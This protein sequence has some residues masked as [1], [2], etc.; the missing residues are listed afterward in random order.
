M[1]DLF[2]P[3]QQWPVLQ[4]P[5]CPTC[6]TGADVV[7]IGDADRID[8]GQANIWHCRSCPDDFATTITFWPVLEGPDCPYCGQGFTCWA[9]IDPDHGGDLWT[10]EHGHE[11]VVDPEGLIVLPKDAA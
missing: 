7:F 1:A 8:G 2:P 9:A 4:P 6:Q 5:D 11:F 10:C 3:P